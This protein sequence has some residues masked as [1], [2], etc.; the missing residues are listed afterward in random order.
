MK[1]EIESLV[2]VIKKSAAAAGGP[3]LRDL[4]ELERLQ[5]GSKNTA[6]FARRTQKRAG[7]L[8]QEELLAARPK[9]GYRDTAG[10]KINGLV[11]NY[12]LVSPIAGFNNFARALP[13]FAIT[14]VA[15]SKQVAKDSD[16]ATPDEKPNWQI[17]ATAVYQP[18]LDDFFVADG[19]EAFHN[20]KWL[21]LSTGHT[22]PAKPAEATAHAN[23]T[24]TGEQN[25][26][27]PGLELCYLAGHRIDSYRADNVPLFDVAAGLFI[28]LSAGIK[29]MDKA[30]N[31][32]TQTT[33]AQL[34]ATIIN[35]PSAVVSFSSN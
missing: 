15:L 19:K 24:K 31:P 2:R 5:L 17:D 16:D 29:I 26:G 6:D 34:C 11:E 20:Q 22:A 1:T 14:I 13:L 7:E 10:H 25:F 23:H 30:G 3:M 33:L 18:L 27:A 9:W 35:N 28:A 4:N 32:I 8:L 12:F 21:R